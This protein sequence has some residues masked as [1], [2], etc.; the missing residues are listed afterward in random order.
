M[1]LQMSEEKIF[2]NRQNIGK[3]EHI[4]E[5]R[6]EAIASMKTENKT[7]SAKIDEY[8]KN[9]KVDTFYSIILWIPRGK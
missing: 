1:A 4:L 9:E 5:E 8:A 7:M 3:L 2:E 6:E